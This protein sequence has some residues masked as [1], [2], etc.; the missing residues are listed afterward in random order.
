MHHD[1]GITAAA[2]KTMGFLM[3]FCVAAIV[4][5]FLH[6]VDHFHV[7]AL[8]ANAEQAGASL[9]QRGKQFA[10]RTDIGA[11]VGVEGKLIAAADQFVG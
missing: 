6:P 8:E 1:A 9:V 7:A 3:I 10:L 2:H 11:A 5:I 4:V